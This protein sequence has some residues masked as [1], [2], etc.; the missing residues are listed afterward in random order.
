MRREHQPL[1]FRLWVR[2]TLTRLVFLA[3]IPSILGAALI[4]KSAAPET[5]RLDVHRP[6]VTVGGSPA[7]QTGWT[8][9][10]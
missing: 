5:M 4:V 2:R 3:V 7:P 10:P 8:V 9:R 6:Q 1:P